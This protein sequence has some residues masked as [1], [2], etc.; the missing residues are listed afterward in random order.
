[1]STILS[2]LYLRQETAKRV[3]TSLRSDADKILMLQHLTSGGNPTLVEADLDNL[4]LFLGFKPDPS[5]PLY[6]SPSIIV[7]PRP[8]R[9][10]PD[11]SEIDYY[12]Q[13]LH[14]L[15]EYWSSA[16]CGFAPLVRHKTFWMNEYGSVVWY[17]YF[18]DEVSL[19]FTEG[20][21][22]YSRQELFDG[23]AKTTNA[24]ST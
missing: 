12:V 19:F 15:K 16:G 17:S 14:K 6:S 18:R 2:K 8:E 1:M 22:I 9:Y 11:F 3:M 5:V 20:Y 21:G 4:T 23:L 7:I 10:P 24:T 13:I